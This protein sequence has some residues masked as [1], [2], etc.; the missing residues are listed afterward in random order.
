VGLILRF[1]VQN[2]HPKAIGLCVSFLDAAADPE[3]SDDSLRAGRAAAAAL[4]SDSAAH[5]PEILSRLKRSAILGRQVLQDLSREWNAPSLLPN[6]DDAQLA[7]LWEL[8][9]NYWPYNLDVTISGGHVVGPGEQAQHWRDT[10][11][12]NLTR[13]GT[14]EAAILL[15]ELAAKHPQLPWLVDKIRIAEERER[16]QQW[17]PVLPEELAK[18][19][20]NSHTRLVRDGA[21]LSSLVV[22]ALVTAG[23]RLART[24]QLLW[25]SHLVK[26]IEVWRPKSEPDV[27]S[28]LAEQ[29]T[30]ELVNSGVVVNREVLVRPTTTRGHGLAVDIQADAPQTSDLYGRRSEPVRCRIELKGNWNPDLLTAME[31]QLAD[32]Y[33]L[34]EGLRDGLYVTAWFDVSLWNDPNGNDSNLRVARSRDRD[35]TAAQLDAQAEALRRLNLRIHSVILDI[36]RPTPSARVG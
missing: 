5:W 4:L 25:N 7:E 35:I 26:G 27:S 13:R 21:D 3:A 30:I 29:L 15:T 9:V 31:T 19:F 8:L 17:A 34:P 14:S 12:D 1:L 20:A 23:S 33:L 10:V 32:D 16:E 36:P 11:I 24:G 28:W 18:L 6:L 22:D 2:G